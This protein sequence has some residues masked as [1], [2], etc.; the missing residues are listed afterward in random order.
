MQGIASNATGQRANALRI[1]MKVT[2]SD[3]AIR[4]SW[5]SM[6]PLAKEFMA[7]NTKSIW[8][9]LPGLA[10]GVGFVAV[11]TLPYIAI[12]LFQLARHQADDLGLSATQLSEKY[13]KRGSHPRYPREN[14]PLPAFSYWLWVEDQIIRLNEVR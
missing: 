9:T 14:S 1:D 11:M 6:A 4:R 5:V 3:F 12:K 8:W 7:M 2:N 10:L 13:A